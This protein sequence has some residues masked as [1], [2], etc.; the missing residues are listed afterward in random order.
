MES[1]LEAAEVDGRAIR[2]E[3][4]EMGKERVAEGEEDEGQARKRARK[5]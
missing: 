2:A 1:L 4:V 3:K 5:E